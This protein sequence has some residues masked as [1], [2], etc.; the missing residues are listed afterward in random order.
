MINTADKLLIML[1]QGG[2]AEIS[3]TLHIGPSEATFESHTPAEKTLFK[4]RLARKLQPSTDT[5]ASTFGFWATRLEPGAFPVAAEDH[6][7]AE[8]LFA[9]VERSQK[10]RLQEEVTSRDLF[11][12]SPLPNDLASV[13][14][15]IAA[16]S[17]ADVCASAPAEGLDERG[18][19]IERHLHVEF[20]AEPISGASLLFT[21]RRYLG[22][23][24]L[25]AVENSVTV[26]DSTGTAVCGFGHSAETENCYRAARQKIL[27]RHP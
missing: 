3:W 16:A 18:R 2:H 27:Q 14:A 24:V 5:A 9:S 23:T 12:P 11:A 21:E 6:L 8:R 19:F 20:H 13:M 22:D 15:F 26:R 25:A 7:N 17:R 4:V 10:E 1:L